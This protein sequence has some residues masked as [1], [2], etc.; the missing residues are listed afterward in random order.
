MNIHLRNFSLFYIS[1]YRNTFQDIKMCSS[2]FLTLI[3]KKMNLLHDIL[4][5]IYGQTET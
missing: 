4:V 1:T 3:L 2:L 5:A